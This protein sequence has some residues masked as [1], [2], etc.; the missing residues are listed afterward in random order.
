MFPIPRP[1]HFR[2][3]LSHFRPQGRSTLVFYVLPAA[4]RVAE[5]APCHFRAPFLAFPRLVL[6]LENAFPFL[7]WV[8]PSFAYLT[9]AP[10]F[11]C[12]FLRARVAKRGG[13]HLLF[14]MLSAA[15]AIPDLWPGNAHAFCISRP[16]AFSG[17]TLC[18]SP[19]QWL[20]DCIWCL[21][22][23]HLLTSLLYSP[24][25]SMA[26]YSCLEC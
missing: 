11:P 24:G 22:L 17:L 21:T 16:M 18:V 13:L 1:R 20:S 25:L 6:F 3:P 10:I 23:A 4:H 9:P 8:I 7:S 12:G 19:W 26:C 2:A 15:L 5:L 14:C